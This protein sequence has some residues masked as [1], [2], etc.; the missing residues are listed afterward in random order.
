[1]S[2]KFII[3]CIGKNIR[4]EKC[5]RYFEW[6]EGKPKNRQQF[7]LPCGFLWF[8]IGSNFCDRNSKKYRRIIHTRQF[9]NGTKENKSI[10]DKCQ[11]E[12]IFPN[13]IRSRIPF[14]ENKSIVDNFHWKSN[15]DDTF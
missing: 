9:L 10:A 14:K 7:S 4:H 1:M 12:I 15:V 2:L 5:R 8:E 3:E 11:Q 13:P 6:N